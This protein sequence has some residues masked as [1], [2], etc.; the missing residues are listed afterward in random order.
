MIE[1]LFFTSIT[2]R[3]IEYMILHENQ[4]FNYKDIREILSIS[5]PSVSTAFKVCKKFGLMKKT[6]RIGPSTL[7]QTNTDSPLYPI[8]KKL[9]MELS[10]KKFEVDMNERE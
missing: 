1:E 2:S 6:R 3:V 4:E 7:Y 9:I 8:L 5:P 10:C